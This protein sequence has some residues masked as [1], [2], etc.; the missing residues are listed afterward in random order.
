VRVPLDRVSGWRVM[1]RHCM[2]RDHETANRSWYWR[3]CQD[4]G[5]H[6]HFVEDRTHLTNDRAAALIATGSKESC[7]FPLTNLAGCGLQDEI[8][9]F[10]VAGV[11]GCVIDFQKDQ[12]C[13]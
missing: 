4:W 13:F 2:Q 10:F 12:G 6:E 9:Q 8:N 3:A 5:V 7:D 11:Y 1:V